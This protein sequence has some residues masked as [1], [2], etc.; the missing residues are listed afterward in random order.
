MGSK[1][2]KC[3]DCCEFIGLGV[4]LDE[5]KA[6]MSY[7]DRDFILRHWAATG[8]PQRKP[9]PLMS[10]KCFNGYHWYKCDLLD[11]QTRLCKDYEN[12]PQIC[13]DCPGKNPKPESLIS[14]RCGFM[15][16]ESRL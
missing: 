15:Q 1:C 6:E 10:D 8:A 4:A 3:G 16:E 13:K 11:S 14:A 7:P 9:N 12:R 2:I 5:I